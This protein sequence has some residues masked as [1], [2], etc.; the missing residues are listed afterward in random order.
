VVLYS[1]GLASGQPVWYEAAGYNVHINLFGGW[2]YV[3]GYSPI[4]YDK[5]TGGGAG[6]PK[7]TTSNPIAIGS[8]PYTTSGDTSTSASDSLDGCGAAPTKDESGPEVI[9]KVSF[10]KP[11]TVTIQTTDDAGAD[12]DPHLYGSLNTGDCLARN[13]SVFSHPVDCGTYYVVVDSFAGQAG[14]YTLKVSFT[15][16]PGKSC[17]SGPPAYSPKGKLGDSCAYPGNKNLPFCNPNLG[18]TTCLYGSSS[19]FCTKPCKGNGDCTAFTGGC[20]KD[21]NGKG[22]YY[23]MPAAYC[24]G[25]KLDAG[26][27]HKDTGGAGADGPAPKPD[28]KAGVEGGA[29]T[30]DGAGGGDGAPGQPGE[31]G[32]GGCSC[33]LQGNGA[34]GCAGAGAGL[35]TLLLLGLLRRRA[36]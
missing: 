27:T 11:G 3:T 14:K 24:A 29:A 35:V 2:S 13:D 34:G 1:L 31:G 17:G 36:R 28:A 20:C 25:V 22:E 19:S 7:G 15:P 21:V 10:T 6:N 9:Y 18:A 30:G 16:A 33:R 5:I 23:C 4:R 26:V 8:L 12:I 32:D